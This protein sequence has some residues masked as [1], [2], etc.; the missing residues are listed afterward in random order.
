MKTYI[1]TLEHPISGEIRYIGKTNSLERRLHYHCTVGIKSN[2][3]LGNWLKF[4]KKL[5]LKPIINILDETEFNWQLLEIYWISQFKTWGFNLLNHTEGGEGCYGGGQWNNTPVSVYTKEGVFVKSFISQKECASYFKTTIP[6]VTSVVTGRV[7]LLHRKYQIKY[8]NSSSNIKHVSS[9]KSY[10]WK[11][12]P[13]VHWLSKKV[14]C[15]EDGLIFNSQT[16]A[17]DFYNIKVTTIN[18]ILNGRTKKTR[19]KKSFRLI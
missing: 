2:N 8:G 5:K 12:K 18:N 13:V 1:Y 16:E 10:E 4:L 7:L 11:N 9:Y 14:E 17:A 3:K 15:I 19:D 6:S